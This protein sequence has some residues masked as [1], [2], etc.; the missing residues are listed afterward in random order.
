[1]KKYP[2][3]HDRILQAGANLLSKGGFSAVTLGALAAEVGMSKGGLFAHFHSKD[4]VHIALLERA[5]A[6]QQSVIAPAMKARK[7]LARL[8][9]LIENQLGWPAKAG[10][11]GGCPIAAGI[12]EFDDGDGPVRERLLTLEKSWRDLLTVN[13]RT[14]IHAGHLRSDLDVGQFV[15][16]L[17]GIYLS[18]HAA[19]RFLRDPDAR[20]HIALQALFARAMPVAMQQ[21]T[22]G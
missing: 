1:M 18:H 20:A 17:C 22:G 21:P 9:L 10:L 19:A 12:F 15:W 14:A 5:E 4:D 7:G 3:T 11:A 2:S 8:K 13:T 6:M 16:D